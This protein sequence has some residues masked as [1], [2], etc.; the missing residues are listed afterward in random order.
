MG[1][2]ETDI[3]TVISNTDSSSNQAFGSPKDKLK[4]IYNTMTHI[5]NDE[6]AEDTK[7]TF[8]K[9]LEVLS[10]LQDIRIKLKT[11]NADDKYWGHNWESPKGTVGLS[12]YQ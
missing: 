2:L 3:A 7:N 9:L 10:E 4:A 6:L 8:S 12:N 5:G 1:G 11:F